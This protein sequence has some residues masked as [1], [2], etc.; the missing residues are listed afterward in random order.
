M[1]FELTKAEP[2]TSRLPL[3]LQ[4]ALPSVFTFELTARCQHR[5]AGCGNVFTHSNV[6]MD[7]A[8]WGSII[9]KL[10][11][12]LQALRI[13]GGEP[14]LHR[15]FPKLMEQI[16]TL[17]VPFVVFTN[18]NWSKPQSM[19]K[20]FQGCANLK[21][22]LV[23]L[24][25][26]DPAAYRQF[27]G[28]DVFEKVLSNIKLATSAGLRVATNTLLLS[29]TVH[30]LS[31]IA[32][33]S[34]S[35]GVANISFGRYYGPP[36]QDFSISAAQLRQALSQISAMRRL[37]HRISLSNCVPTCF[38]PDGDFGGGGC[39]SGFT[40]CTIGPAGDVRPCT[41]SEVV[42][43]QMPNDDIAELWQSSALSQWRNLIPND[44]LDCQALNVC[45][46]GCRAVAQKLVLP[47]DPL[48]VGPLSKTNH[49]LVEFGMHDRPKLSYS[50][51]P[52]GFGFALSGAGHYVTLS[53]KS[54]PILD[55]LDGNSTIESI[56]DEFGSGS[57]ELIGGL[58]HQHLL[59]M[60]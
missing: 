41:H 5:C 52:T 37:D 51:I 39:T 32:E 18:G 31:E 2:G 55:K 43:G 29:T 4:P 54:K 24:H 23:S 38:S 13:T 14:T 16:D 28:A 34:F 58:L 3:Y 30:Q 60:Q 42:L 22:L 59:E 57:L 11:P 35:A 8:Q 7:A 47:H 6:E 19:I 45:R 21:G 53:Q 48:H 12:Y 27:T 36:L 17:G 20:M 15:Q 9:T 49:E 40:H 33:L 46:G 26:A 56:L 10:R 25:G 44:C 50:V 1:N